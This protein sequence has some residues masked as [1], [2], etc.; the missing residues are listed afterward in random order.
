MFIGISHSAKRICVYFSDGVDHIEDMLR[1][2]L[3]AAIG[4]LAYSG[5]YCV[6][7]EVTPVDFAHYMNFHNR[8][9]FR[10]KYE[11]APFSWAV[12]L[13]DHYPEGCSAS[14]LPMLP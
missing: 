6:G 2:Q 8:R 12:R 14:D 11:P 10:D 7:K 9:M 4:T 3:I 1:K 5:S 13:P